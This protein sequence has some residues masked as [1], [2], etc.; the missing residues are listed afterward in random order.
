MST[1]IIRKKERLDKSK[2]WIKAE[3]QEEYIDFIDLSIQDYLLADDDVEIELSDYVYYLVNNEL[4]LIEAY[5]NE[6]P[7]LF[8]TSE[9]EYL[10]D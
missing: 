9:F 10:R 8:F 6:K 1:V 4:L 5:I 7:T 2:L 3:V